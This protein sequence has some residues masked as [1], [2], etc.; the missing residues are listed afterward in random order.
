MRHMHQYLDHPDYMQHF[1]LEDP[2]VEQFLSQYS[3]IGDAQVPLTAVFESR[4]QDYTVQVT[5]LHTR[6]S[7]GEVKL[8][9]EPSSAQAPASMLKFNVVM[10]EMT[11]F[12]E[13]EGTDVH[14]QMFVPGISEDGGATTTQ[15]IAGFDES[16]VKFESVH[17]MSLPQ[18][19]PESAT[20]Q[21]AIF[22]SSYIDAPGQTPQLG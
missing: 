20:L 14:A 17:S 4:V 21:I 13:R 10:H 7:I 6:H 1:G 8:S 12:P 18:D 3:L 9:L 22:G 11:G 2:F 15:M 19:S 5:S 16:A